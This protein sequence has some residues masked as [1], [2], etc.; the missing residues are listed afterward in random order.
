MVLLQ[1][2]NKSFKNSWK[3]NHW[4]YAVFKA[5]C[6]KTPV[7]RRTLAFC[8]LFWLLW[9]SALLICW[10]SQ[11]GVLFAWDLQD[12]RWVVT[13]LILRKASIFQ[14]FV[15]NVMPMSRNYKKGKQLRKA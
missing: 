9:S 2:V 13:G 11:W 14:G 4:F 7:S 15:Q 12:Q 10:Y 5:L 6:V 1:Q 8:V 3:T